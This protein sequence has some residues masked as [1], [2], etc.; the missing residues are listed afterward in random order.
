M[1]EKRC[2]LLAQQYINYKVEDNDNEEE[3]NNLTSNKK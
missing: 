1:K 2:L 3:L